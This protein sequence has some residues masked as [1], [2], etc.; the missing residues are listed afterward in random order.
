M[1][2]AGHNSFFGN[3]STLQGKAIFSNTANRLKYSQNEPIGAGHVYDAIRARQSTQKFSES[4]N[5][6]S[7]N[8]PLRTF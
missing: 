5:P 6:V 1:Q 7:Q 3:S 4:V 8:D 2:Q